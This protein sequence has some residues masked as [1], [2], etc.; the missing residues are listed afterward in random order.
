[1]MRTM[2]NTRSLLLL[3]ALLFACSL[4]LRQALDPE[5]ER[6][7]TIANSTTTT[8]RR[9]LSE[10]LKDRKDPIRLLY[11]ITTLA[12]YDAGT[13]ATEKGFDRLKN[14]LIPVVKEG[15]LSMLAKGFV[16][17]VFVVCHYEMTRPEL[18]RDA[19]PPDVHVRYWDNAAP[20]S[21]KPDKRE[22]P[23]AK[24]WKNTLALA[25]QHRFVVKDNLFDYDLFLN[26]EDDMIIHGDMVEHHVTMTQKLFQLRETAP[27]TVSDA[28]LKNVFGPLTKDQ[29]KRS[30][31]GLLRVEVLLDEATYGTQTE[32]D[33]VPV[34][35]HPDV[36]PKPCCH[37]DAA[38]SDKRPSSPGSDKLFLWETNILALGVRHIEGLGW[39]AL[40]RGPRERNGEKGMTMSDY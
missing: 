19:L 39:V 3:A 36:D 9:R 20:I 22:D 14:L 24:L 8:S 28:Q 31:P 18:L 17:D 34:A 16:V 25:R 7:S 10:Q 27:D 40:L 6:I 38:A 30:Y 37:L 15:V 32:L 33:P 23:K 26:F 4:P 29:L 2:W 11:T 35:S 13:R 1:M 21:Y 12:E 5:D